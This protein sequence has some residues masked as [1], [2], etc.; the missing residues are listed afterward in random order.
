[1][2]QQRN[3]QNPQ[4]R[5]YQQQVRKLECF[6]CGGDHFVRDCPYKKPPLNQV[7]GLTQQF[8]AVP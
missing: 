5:P 7:V 2:I 3:G 1:M 4:Q 6:R 8:S